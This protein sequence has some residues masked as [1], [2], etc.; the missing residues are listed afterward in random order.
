MLL[1]ILRAKQQT[2]GG[3][4]KSVIRKITLFAL[5]LLY[6]GSFS[7]AQGCGG[8]F[9]IIPACS[10][11]GGMG[12]TIL[13]DGA[14]QSFNL[15]INTVFTST[16]SG[17]H[18]V[19]N[20]IPGG[21]FY[22][23]QNPPSHS[24]DI[25]GIMPAATGNP[26]INSIIP[27]AATCGCN[28][29]IVVSATSVTVP[30]GGP[31]YYQIDGPASFQA[32]NNSGTFTGLCPGSY[33]VTVASG[34]GC[35]V[36]QQTTVPDNTLAVTVT[37]SS[38]CVGETLTANVTGGTAPYNFQWFNGVTPL[39]TAQTQIAAT[40]G[41]YTVQVT[42]ASLCVITSAPVT[43]QTCCSLAFA[44]GSPSATPTCAGY[45]TVTAAI[46]GGTPP[47]SYQLDAGIPVVTN[48]TSYTFSLLSQ[49]S[50]TV[51]V[52]DSS[53]PACT[54][55]GT[56]V[57]EQGNFALVST[58]T[59]PSCSNV[60]NGT[61][62]ITTSGGV[63]PFDY[64]DGITL[65][66]GQVSNTFTFMNEAPG[67]YTV[68]ATDS[69]F[70]D[71][72][73]PNVVVG[74]VQA[75]T[76]TI[77]GNMDIC[78]QTSPTLMAVASPAGDTFS[79]TWT[80]NGN[81]FGT[82]P[83][84]VPNQAG[85]YTVTVT[86]ESTSPACS[87]STSIVVNE[88]LTAGITAS[89][90]QCITTQGGSVQLTAVPSQ[91]G[92]YNYTWTIPGGG[93]ATGNPLTATVPGSYT[94]TITDPNHPECSA[95]ASIIVGE[96][97]LANVSAVADCQGTVTVSGTAYS[98]NTVTAVSGALTGS[99]T[100]AN[101]GS[102]TITFVGVANGTYTF[103]VTATDTIDSVTPPCSAQ[104]TAQV[105]VGSANLSNVTAAADCQGNVT[106]S[107][108]ADAGDAISI[109]GGLTGSTT[110]DNTGHFSITFNNVSNG[111][112]T[113]TVT[114]TNTSVTP[115][116]VSNPT[117]LMVTVGKA[118][119]SEVQAL[120]DCQ[121]NVT[122]SGTADANDSIT[123]VLAGSSMTTTADNTGHFSVT[124]TN[125]SNGTYMITVSA[126]NSTVTPPCTTSVQVQVTVATATLT[127]VTASVVCPG[128][129][130]ISGTAD[131]GAQI[132]VTLN[133]APMSTTADNAGHFSVTY[134]GITQGIYSY[135]VVATNSTPCSA[136]VTQTVTVP[137]CEGGSL[138]IFQ[139]CSTSV[140]CDGLASFT[141]N[142]KNTGG[143]AATGITV[144]ETLPCC[145]SF[146]SGTGAGWTFVQSGNN[147]IAKYNNPLPA[148][149]IASFS[150]TAKANCCC[151]GK[152][153]AT[154]IAS[155]ISDQTTTPVT[156]VCVTKIVK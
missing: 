88:D 87:A 103:T 3:I 135:T 7:S 78:G 152:K 68:T 19:F 92:T 131:A 14:S 2:I 21:S 44:A 31:I 90:S 89:P 85:T 104:T 11:P 130:T 24:C 72:I 134:T 42:D 52:T 100:A 91:T 29:S 49:G 119:L 142:V 66:T 12:G 132:N 121:G 123:V 106:V 74:T 120:A 111:T 127:N 70:C 67:T 37:P 13:Y 36:V 41:S 133:G 140:S 93:S 71:I 129:V 86:D 77:I 38:A 8:T 63:P 107:G 125:I 45:G 138:A 57:I 154:I 126:T 60:N 101:D 143:T 82:G 47:Y 48:A 145:F 96:A 6:L 35:Q 97:F 155:A 118:N 98:G 9:T 109:T 23:V 27:T 56:A 65:V 122:V 22:Q 1:K 94:V 64:T 30:V 76:V 146:L 25:Q 32:Y 136:S 147:V 5:C 75:P 53:T 4:M 110:A 105:T 69:T 59:T 73:V 18:V 46:T 116:C 95:T 40:V 33:A 80:L 34:V 58:S 10:A 51:T 99:T 28:G 84:I 79:Y 20:N 39:G 81:P 148:G 26:T 43:V 117:T 17:T 141:V 108:V 55:T 144:T 50:H 128:T 149:Q 114:A 102:F 62:T 139:C 113:L 151:A 150:F 16:G 156:D 61:I 112:Y 83:T 115:P 137:S 153:K 124:F 54:I 15:F